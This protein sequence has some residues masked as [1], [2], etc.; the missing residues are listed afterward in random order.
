MEAVYQ[1][2]HYRITKAIVSQQVSEEIAHK[3]KKF[4]SQ[5]KTVIYF[6]SNDQ[7]IMILAFLD[8]VRPQA[9]ELIDYFNQ[10]H[11]YTAVITGDTKQS[12]LFLKDELHLKKLGAIICLP[13]KSIK[14]LIYKKDTVLL[15]W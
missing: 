7:V 4:L 12:A 9:F 13:K 3:T 15:L 6:I 8:K 10:K 2:N 5:G 14:S 11:I 1:N